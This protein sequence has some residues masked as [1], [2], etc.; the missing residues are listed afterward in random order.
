MRTF[1][2]AGAAAL[3]AFAIGT[4]LYAPVAGILPAVF[5]FLAVA[6]GIFINR[7]RKVDAALVPLV[8]LLE[9]QKIDEA[10]ALIDQ[11]KAEHGPWVPGLEGQLDAQVGLLDYMQMKFDKAMPKLM[12]GRWRN[13]VALL[14]IGA[15]H[16]RKNEET[17]AW[18]FLTEAEDAANKDP[19]VFVVSAA[20]RMKKGQRDDALKTLGKG[21]EAVD[22]KA[23]IERLQRVI[24]NNKRIQPDKLPQMWMQIWP[25]D[26]VA[27][28]K[29]QGYGRPGGPMM[30]SHAGGGNR[31][32]RR[33]KK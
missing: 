17:E 18:Q 3:V 29:K 25:E 26:L 11:V 31:A 4:A 16:L 2:A 15:T 23:P 30:P 10:V 1:Y 8:P 6:V 28:L 27:Q 33:A 5:A 22:N 32:A 14:C 24:A 12:A 13:P 9:A 19:N 21:L 7:R 20:L